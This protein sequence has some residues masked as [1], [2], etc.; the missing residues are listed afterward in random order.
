MPPN[1]SLFSS[2]E[3]LDVD[4]TFR[5]LRRPRAQSQLIPFGNALDVA[6]GTSRLAHGS[7][8]PYVGTHLVR[9]HVFLVF[10]DDWAAKRTFLPCLS[11]GGRLLRLAGGNEFGL[12][13]GGTESDVTNLYYNWRQDKTRSNLHQ[14]DDCILHNALSLFGIR[15]VVLAGFCRLLLLDLVHARPDLAVGNAKAHD[16]IDKG[17]ALARAGRNAEL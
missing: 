8:T 17:L 6:V 2:K 4:I 11:V 16:V 5:P 10:V 3:R 13:V 7:I 1:G 9:R 15:Y 14:L 12:P